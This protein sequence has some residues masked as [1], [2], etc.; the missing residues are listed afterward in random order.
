MKI[1]PYQTEQSE[2]SKIIRHTFKGY[3]FY[4][5]TSEIQENTILNRGILDLGGIALPQTIMS[6]NKD[7]AIERGVTSGLYFVLSFL[8]PYILLPIFN[9]KALS[10]TKIIKNFESNE[11]SSLKFLKNI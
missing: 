6:N 7:E 2:D 3:G 8:T 10:S 1:S 5:A 9:K 4:N 11:K